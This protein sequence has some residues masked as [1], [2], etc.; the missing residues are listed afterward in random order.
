MTARNHAHGT[1][2]ANGNVP[3]DTGVSVNGATNFLVAAHSGTGT[4]TAQRKGADGTWRDIPDVSFTAVG[5]KECLL[6]GQNQVRFVVSSASSLSASWE[7][8]GS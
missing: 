2:T 8:I 4:L 5:E 7:I 3:D 6:K 1:A